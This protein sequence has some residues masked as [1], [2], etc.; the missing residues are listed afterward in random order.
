MNHP[1]DCQ[2]ALTEGK[3]LQ[4]LSLVSPLHSRTAA[5]GLENHS[6]IKLGDCACKGGKC[7]DLGESPQ[8]VRAG[9]KI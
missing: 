9:R 8:E 1:W 6:I 4:N 3:A 5:R 7:E 2:K